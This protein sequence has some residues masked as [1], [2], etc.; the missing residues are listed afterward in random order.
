MEESV[1]RSVPG[2]VI[3]RKAE[4]LSIPLNNPIVQALMAY[5]QKANLPE[6]NLIDIGRVATE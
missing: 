2:L 3:N 4:T 6:A 1:N 5:C